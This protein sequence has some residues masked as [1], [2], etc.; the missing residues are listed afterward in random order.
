[1]KKRKKKAIRKKYVR[2]FKEGFME[3]AGFTIACRVVTRVLL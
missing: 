3:G 1:M 2:K